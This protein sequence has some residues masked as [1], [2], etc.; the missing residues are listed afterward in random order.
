MRSLKSVFLLTLLGLPL[1]ASASMNGVDFSGLFL[2]IIVL[3]LG[4]PILL[5]DLFSIKAKR[6]TYL[7][8]LVWLNSS[9]S[10]AIFIAQFSLVPEGNP[11]SWIAIVLFI[12][13]GIYFYQRR[14]RKFAPQVDTLDSLDD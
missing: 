11:L 9:A 3:F 7:L 8:V 13:F 1:L 4:G 2:A 5:V 6:K 10:L 14:N 12:V